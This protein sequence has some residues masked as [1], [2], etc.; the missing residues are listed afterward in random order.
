M[1]N[2]ALTIVLIVF[3]G[4]AIG[5]AVIAKKNKEPILKDM[6]QQQSETVMLLKNLEQ[7]LSVPGAGGADMSAI[8]SALQ[9]L[10][11][12]VAIVEA[13]LAAGPNPFGG[14]QDRAQQGPP[15][16]DYTKVYDI[17]EA[18]S[19]IRGKKDAPVTI[20]EFVDFQ[21]PFCSRFHSTVNQVMEAYPNDVRYILKNYPLSFHPQAR[22][23][24]KAAF[25]AGEQGKYWEMVELI[26]EDNSGLSE[27]KYKVYAEKLGLN[28]NKFSKDITDKDAQWEEWIEADMALGER[29]DVQGTPT[30]YLNGRKTM[31]RDLNAFKSEIDAILKK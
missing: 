8:L 15:P 1:S 20:V 11:K 30:F 4:V 25:A 23:A 31:S 17:E 10:Q 14:G 12:R 19:P 22:P 18:N 29:S 24:A 7:K 3:L 5:G 6:M 27:E 28:L 13:K 21:C 26:L 16:E 9:D 2:R